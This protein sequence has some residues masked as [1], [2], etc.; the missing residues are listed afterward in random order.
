MASGRRRGSSWG[1]GAD[2]IAGLTLGLDRGGRTAVRRVAA[3][4]AAVVGAMPVAGAALPAIAQPAASS[5]SAASAAPAGPRTGGVH[6]ETLTIHVSVQSGG[7]QTTGRRI[8][9]DIAAE[10]RRR[11]HDA[12]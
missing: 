9:R 8:D 10:L 5:M 2:T 7:D 4:G 1:L 12:A 3:I 11:L 6:I